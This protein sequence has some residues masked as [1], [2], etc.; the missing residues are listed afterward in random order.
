[1]RVG[2][3]GVPFN[4]AAQTDAEAGAPAALR[5]ADLVATLA[6][7][8]DVTD[9]GD[10]D[11]PSGSAERDGES[12]LIA[13]E[14]FLAMTANVRAAVTS[15]YRDGQMPLILGG[16]SAVLLGGLLA[17]RDQLGYGAGLLFVDG[18]EDA[19]PPF[20]SVTGE[21]G[22]MELGLALG[23][24]RP[25][26]LGDLGAELPVVDPN[27]VA[28]LGPR[29]ADELRSEGIESVRHRVIVMNDGELRDAGVAM[30]VQRWLKHFGNRP[31][32]FWFHLDLDVLSTEA[33]PAVSYPQPGGLAWDE[34]SEI[35]R[36]VFAAEHLIGID[37]TGYN[38]DKDAD[39]TVANALVAALAGA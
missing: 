37:I 32:R 29:D 33:N 2:I 34:V 35:I 3:I 15:A 14:T 22:D 16:D 30:T 27:E 36:I 9:R 8:G 7:L 23:L 31:G 12:G 26:K 4:S 17:A 38:P 11:V 13:P 18:H 28:L 1:M 21:A 24:S 10:V 39:G 25:D 20:G 19:W 5:A 6:P